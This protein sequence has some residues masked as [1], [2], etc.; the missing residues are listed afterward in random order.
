MATPQEL[1]IDFDLDIKRSESKIANPTR[2]LMMSILEEAG[3]TGSWGVRDSRR[4]KKKGVQVLESFDIVVRVPDCF[5]RI[6]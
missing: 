4:I 2:N 5:G 3:F 1:Q 6:N